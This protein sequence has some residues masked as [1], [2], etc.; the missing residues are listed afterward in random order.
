MRVIAVTV[1][2]FALL[3]FYFLP[4][5]IAL[6]RGHHQR[7]T[8]FLLNLLLG[9]TFFGWVGALV[10]AETRVAPDEAN[11]RPREIRQSP[12]ALSSGAAAA[13]STESRCSNCNA[14]LAADAKF[15]SACG[16]AV[17]SE[18]DDLAADL[19]E[20]LKPPPPR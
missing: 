6:G 11:W 8:I 18:P 17:A 4:T 13:A 14:A 10:W 9:W 1:V 15:C 7:T 19:V 2:V 5:L 12:K 3:T 20:R 16:S